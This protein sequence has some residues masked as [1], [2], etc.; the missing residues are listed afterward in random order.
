[1]KVKVK[2]LSRVQL[3]ATPWTIASQAPLSMGLSRQEYWGGL[4]FPAP[5]DPPDPGVA[6]QPPAS[7]VLA[8]GFFTTGPPGKPS[9]CVYAG[10]IRL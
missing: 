3:F 10:A 1:M 6:P 4:P 8:G 9:T 5:G 7:A 2:L